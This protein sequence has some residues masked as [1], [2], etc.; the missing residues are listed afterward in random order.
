MSYVSLILRGSEMLPRLTLLMA[1]VAIGLFLS[2]G[3]AP[4]LLTYDREAI[5]H[6]EWWRLVSGHFVHSDGEHAFWDIFALL[7]IGA[8]LEQRGLTKFMTATVTGLFAVNIW[9]IWGIPELTYYCGLSGILNTL[10]AVFLIELWFDL[11]KPKRQGNNSSNSKKMDF[12]ALA[13]LITG[14]SILGKI[15]VEI[16]LGQALFTDTAW[17]GVPSVHL[18]GVVGGV[19]Y[20]TLRDIELIK[21]T[22]TDKLNF[23]ELRMLE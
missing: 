4:E 12:T 9:L 20:T 1:L 22:R 11:K 15:L 21:K 13:I 19:L 5:I 6:G 3:A 17:P 10:L 18:A 14:V 8:L 7:L 16:N 2:F 23:S